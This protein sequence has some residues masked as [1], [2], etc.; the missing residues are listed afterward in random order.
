VKASVL[1][2]SPANA[3]PEWVNSER[4][5]SAAAIPGVHVAADPD[6]V[7]AAKL[8]ATTSGHVVLFDSAGQVRFHGGI[9]GA[10]GHE[11]P[12]AGESAVLAALGGTSEP[13]ASTPVFGCAIAEAVSAREG[14][15]Q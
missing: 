9:T 4:W 6:G 13:A 8:G 12:N 11:G 2:Y 14:A 10:R 1:V 5:Q 3:S 7:W 15:A